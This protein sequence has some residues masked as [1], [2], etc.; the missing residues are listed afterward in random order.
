MHPD[1]DEPVAPRIKDLVIL[2]IRWTFTH[3]TR[4]SFLILSSVLRCLRSLTWCDFPPMTTS[5]GCYWA[6]ISDSVPCTIVGRDNPPCFP[7]SF[8]CYLLISPSLRDRLHPS[9]VYFMER[10]LVI[11]KRLETGHLNL[12]VIHYPFL[13]M[14]SMT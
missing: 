10:I 8:R 14:C 13:L 4:S 6:N 7:F 1:V 11:N 2:P 3:L 5:F 9:E 12:L